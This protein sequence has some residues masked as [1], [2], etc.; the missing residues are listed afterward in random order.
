MAAQRLAM[1][2][3]V[4]AVLVQLDKQLPVPHQVLAALDYKVV[5]VV[6]QLT[7]LVAAVV[8]FGLD[9]ITLAE[10]VDKVVVVQPLLGIAQLLEQ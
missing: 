6:L 8:V 7:M 2:L 3:A 10:Q 9:H 4:A 5:L 1:V